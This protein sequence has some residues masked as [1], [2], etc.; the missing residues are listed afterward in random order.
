MDKKPEGLESLAATEWRLRNTD[1]WCKHCGLH[2]EESD[3]QLCTFFMHAENCSSAYKPRD[4]RRIICLLEECDL[5][6]LERN[7]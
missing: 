3:D 6:N 7:P 5:R 2:P 4:D 1:I